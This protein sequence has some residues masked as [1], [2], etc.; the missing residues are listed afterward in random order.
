MSVQLSNRI[1]RDMERAVC[2]ILQDTPFAPPFTIPEGSALQRQVQPLQ[3]K[4]LSEYVTNCI[5]NRNFTEC[6]RVILQLVRWFAEFAQIS[7]KKIGQPIVFSDCSFTHFFLTDSGM[8]YR[9][10]WAHWKFGEQADNAAALLAQIERLN[11]DHAVKQDLTDAMWTY[12]H[13]LTELEMER[14][15]EKSAQFSTR[16]EQLVEKI[17]NA[18]A[19]VFVGGHASRMQYY[20]KYKVKIGRYTFLEYIQYALDDLGLEHAAL[21]VFPGQK[22]ADCG[23]PQWEDEVADIGP[24][25]GLQTALKHSATEL[26]FVIPCDMPTICADVIAFLLEQ[27]EP[28]DSAV[29]PS[30]NG[31]IN[32]LLGFYRT[33]QSDQL[34]QMVQ[35]GCRRPWEFARKISAKIVELPPR[36][37]THV[38][39]FNS[40]Q[41]LETQSETLKQI[42]PPTAFLKFK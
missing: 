37:Q 11:L 23:L 20:P 31:K 2:R 1:A 26:V 30:V 42:L 4:N 29:L 28:A 21:S 6:K 38:M 7:I 24:I 34:S 12:Y 40:M 33:N 10:K 18:T 9:T 35:N 13:T 25:S 36:L 8:L 19:V 5:N 3:G 17:R 16:N 32:P 22:I 27:L 39:S 15:A 41:E 14:V